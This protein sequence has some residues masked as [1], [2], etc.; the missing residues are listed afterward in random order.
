MFLPFW[1][2]LEYL[3]RDDEMFPFEPSAS[4]HLWLFESIANCWRDFHGISVRYSYFPRWSVSIYVRLIKEWILIIQSAN[5]EPDNYQCSIDLRES[6]PGYWVCS[7]GYK[8]ISVLSKWGRRKSKIFQDLTS[9]RPAWN[10]TCCFVS[11]LLKKSRK[12]WMRWKDKL[13]FHLNYITK[14]WLYPPASIGL[15]I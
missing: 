12:A 1:P 6:R 2:R 11:S 7:I 3:K 15:T 14:A 9:L 10:V 13:C 8:T 4:W 5:T